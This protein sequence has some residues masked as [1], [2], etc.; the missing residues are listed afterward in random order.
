MFGQRQLPG[1]GSSA[2]PSL[3]TVLPL[4]PQVPNHFIWLIFFYWLFHSSMN[5]VAE[6]LRFGDREFYRDWW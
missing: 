4:S 6:V 5:A 2:A 3:L 1:G